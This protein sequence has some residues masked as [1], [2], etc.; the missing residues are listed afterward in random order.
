MEFIKERTKTVD[1]LSDEQVYKLYTQTMFSNMEKN[2]PHKNP[3]QLG[4]NPEEIVKKIKQNPSLYDSLPTYF[5][6]HPLVAFEASKLSYDDCTPDNTTN[7]Y[8]TIPT[9]TIDNIQ[10]MRQILLNEEIIY[11]EPLP[12]QMRKTCQ[13]KRDLMA[14]LRKSD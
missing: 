14:A 4:T 3:G 13:A 12:D 6:D 10:A 9:G 2:C 8:I 1:K 11:I 7:D 5:K